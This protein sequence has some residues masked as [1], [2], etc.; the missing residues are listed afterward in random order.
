MKIIS[1]YQD[2]KINCEIIIG[3]NSLRDAYMC[4]RAYI[5]VF[6]YMYVQHMMVMDS[7]SLPV[8]SARKTVRNYNLRE[9][10]TTPSSI[11]YESPFPFFSAA[12]ASPFFR[13]LPQNRRE[14]ML[15]LS[16]KTRNSRDTFG[17]FDQL[18]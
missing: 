4:V 17:N 3:Q 6:T 5:C 12:R 13:I 16:R 18:N 15:Y 1:H 11:V 14:F 10:F 2:K 7:W 8:C 9:C